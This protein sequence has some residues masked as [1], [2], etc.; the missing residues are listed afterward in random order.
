MNTSNPFYGKNVVATGKLANYT[1]EGIKSTLRSLG[2]KPTASVT[3]KTDYLIIGEK[4]GG[5][6]LDDA[7]RHGTATITEAEFEAMLS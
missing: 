1:R 3:E 7:R 5:I 2:A 6:K 4:P